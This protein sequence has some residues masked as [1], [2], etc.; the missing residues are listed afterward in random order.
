MSDP[1]Y[2]I[3]IKRQEVAQDIIDSENY[4]EITAEQYEQYKIAMS[5]NYHVYFKERQ[6]KISDESDVFGNMQF[7]VENEKWIS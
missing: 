6:L 1:K 5:F 7:D 2:Y 4:T 3:N